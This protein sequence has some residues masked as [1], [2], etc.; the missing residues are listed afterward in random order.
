MEQTDLAVLRQLVI[1]SEQDGDDFNQNPWIDAPLVTPRHAVRTLWNEHSVRKWCRHGGQQLFICPAEA[2]IGGHSLTIT[3]Q[4][5]LALKLNSRKGNVRR[6]L[7][8]NVELAKGM[9]VLI[10]NNIETDLDITNGSRG[11][12]VDIILHPD[13]PP[14]GTDSI[15]RLKYMPLC[16]LVR[17]AQTLQHI[18][19]DITGGK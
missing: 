15:V 16:V 11:E 10:T 7:P 14:I 9:K 1:S 8:A 3:E 5:H 19:C 6:E 13:E 2:T 17:L 4:Y 12:I 18:I